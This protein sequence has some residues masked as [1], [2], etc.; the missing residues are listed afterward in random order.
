[1]DNFLSTTVVI[2]LAI[3]CIVYFKSFFNNGKA[4]KIFSLYLGMCLFTEFMLRVLIYFKN[5]NLI[6]TH[7]YFIMQFLLLSFFYHELLKNKL[8]KR[9]IRYY[10]VFML[11]VLIFRFFLFPELL[12]QFDLFEIFFT[13]VLYLLFVV[14]LHKCII[15]KYI[16]FAYK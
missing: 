16:L 9:L 14:I 2:A 11:I 12:M 15:E 10:A 8:K 7:F 3:N 13:Y 4:F 5:Q 1:M 6:M